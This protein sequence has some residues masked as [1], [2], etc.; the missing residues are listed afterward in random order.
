MTW[1][2]NDEGDDEVMAGFADA[3]EVIDVE[4]ETRSTRVQLEPP[5]SAPGGHTLLR[6]RPLSP[7]MARRPNVVSVLVTTTSGQVLYHR[8]V[9]R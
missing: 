3:E 5:S 6:V 4:G 7:S 9:R 2:P 8:G 1:D